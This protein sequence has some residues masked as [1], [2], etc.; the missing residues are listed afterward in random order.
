MIFS[1]IVFILVATAYV[2]WEYNVP[3]NATI[4]DI[5]KD[6]VDV[7]PCVILLIFNRPWAAIFLSLCLMANMFIYDSWIMGGL[8][9]A[10]A[11]G[12]ASVLA[13]LFSPFDILMAIFSVGMIAALTVPIAIAYKGTAGFRAAL[14]VYSVLAISPLIYAFSKT[15]NPGFLCL[16]LG[17]I[18]LGLYG[19]CEKKWVKVAAN[20]LYFLG[21]CLVPM[22]L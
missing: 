12:S 10:T 9:F 13:S 21:T 18:G 3:K 1:L 17:D 5:L 22:S 11:Y 15:I 16:A 20:I 7:S 19:I 4:M 8:L 14:C 6:F 2:L